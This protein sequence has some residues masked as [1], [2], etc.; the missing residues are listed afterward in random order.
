M[1]LGIALIFLTS[2]CAQ[3]Q[4]QG[5]VVHA[6][7]YVEVVPA[8][9]ADPSGI[10]KQLAEASRR[11]QG[12]LN[13]EI[14]QQIA[15]TNQFVIFETWKDQQSY[16]AHLAAMHA[17]QA[18]AELAP[19]LVAPID[20]RLATPLVSEA[21]QTPPAGAIYGVSHVAVLPE[22]IGD[23]NEALL[24]YAAATRAAAGNLR[25]YPIRDRSRSNHFAM[26]EIWSDQMSIDAYE[27]AVPSKQ[28]RA[29]LGPISGPLYDRRWYKAF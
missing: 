28:F 8:S 13:F 16:D 11:E 22:R 2:I 24:K 19:L 6:T 15:P 7:S 18:K 21:L 23:M 10:L 1:K 14:A 29:I 26:I 5:P 12:V 4:Q 25:Y 27:A 3:A 17:K 20:T 9:V